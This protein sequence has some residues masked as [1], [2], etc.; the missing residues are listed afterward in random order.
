VLDLQ[1]PVLLPLLLQLPLS[2]IVFAMPS[3]SG[4]Q[5]LSWIDKITAAGGGSGLKMRPVFSRSVLLFPFGLY[6]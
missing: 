1:N 4:V 5:I 2:T 3:A 6:W